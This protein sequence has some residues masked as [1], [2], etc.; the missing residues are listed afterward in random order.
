MLTHHIVVVVVVVVV[1]IILTATVL[2]IHHP[3]GVR[4]TTT[5][6]VFG[7][8]IFGYLLQY[9]LCI[10]IFPKREIELHTHF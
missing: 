9:L 1:V 5:V 3:Y 6:A 2:I 10:V 8:M 4:V 7:M